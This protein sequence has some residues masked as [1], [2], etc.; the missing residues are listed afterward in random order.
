MIGRGHLP[1]GPGERR[2]LCD[3]FAD[4]LETGHTLEESLLFLLQLTDEETDAEMRIKVVA[5]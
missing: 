2:Q 3:L 4:L 1:H 5:A